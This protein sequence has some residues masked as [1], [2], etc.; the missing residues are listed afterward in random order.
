MGCGEHDH[1]RAY[2][3][4][5]DPEAE[6]RARS[7]HRGISAEQDRPVKI[8]DATNRRAVARLLAAGGDDDRVFERRVRTIVDRVR[9]GGDPA[10]ERFAR[11]FDGAEPPLEVTAREIRVGASTVDRTVRRAIARAA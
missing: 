7:G 1:R 4:R 5:S 9:D 6:S 3:P 10:L 11:K 2:R 8:I